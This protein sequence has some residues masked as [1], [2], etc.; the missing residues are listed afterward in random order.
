MLV[1]YFKRMWSVVLLKQ[2]LK[3]A[4][5]F[6]RLQVQVSC[7]GVD[8]SCV[9]LCVVWWKVSVLEQMCASNKRYASE[10]PK[11]E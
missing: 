8:S 9:V 6:K 10:D 3:F 11:H 7:S 1:S 4:P 2:E 5:A